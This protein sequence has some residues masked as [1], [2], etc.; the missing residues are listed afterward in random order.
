MLLEDVLSALFAEQFQSIL[1]DIPTVGASGKSSTLS[2]HPRIKKITW[3]NMSYSHN[4]S[5][6]SKYYGFLFK[7]SQVL[8][9]A[10]S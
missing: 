5:V 4:F 7:T 2:T 8:F 1:G 6:F 3:L 9:C 10:N